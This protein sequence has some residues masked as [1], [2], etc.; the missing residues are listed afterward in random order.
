ML[1]KVIFSVSLS[2]YFCIH[3]AHAFELAPTNPVFDAFMLQGPA[4]TAGETDMAPAAQF[5]PGVIP[6]P[7]KPEVHVYEPIQDELSLSGGILEISHY[8]LRDPN[9]DGNFEDSLLTAVK[10]QGY[11]GS[12]WSFATFGAL[13]GA[14]QFNQG[15]VIDGNNYSENHLINAHLFDYGPCEGGNLYMSASYLARYSGPVQDTDDPY[16]PSAQGVWCDTCQPSFYVDAVHFLPGRSGPEDV[17]YIKQAILEYGP[18]ATEMFWDSNYYTPLDAGYSYPAENPEGM[19]HAVVIVGWDD[20]LTISE[21]DQPGA[22]IVRNS[23]GDGWGHDGYFYVSYADRMFAKNSLA[24]YADQDDQLLPFDQLYQHDPLGM[25]S[26]LFYGNPDTVYGANVFNITTSGWLKAIGIY[27]YNSDTQC[28]INIY[29][30]A[31]V[32]GNTATF[33]ALATTQATEPL[34][35]GYHT[36]TLDSPVHISEG[37][38]MAIVVTYTHLTQTVRCPIEHRFMGYSS[39]AAASPGESYVSNNGLTF[40]DITTL[41]PSLENDNVCIKALVKVD[42]DIDVDPSI[43]LFSTTKS[44]QQVAGMVHM[45]KGLAG[46]TWTNTSTSESG[47]FSF[48]VYEPQPLTDTIVPFSSSIPLGHYQNYIDIVAYDNT[49]LAIG[50]THITITRLPSGYET[51]EIP[52]ITTIEIP[53]YIDIPVYKTVTQYCYIWNGL[54]LVK[55]PC[56]VKTVID[57][58]ETVLSHY[59][60]T[61]IIDGYETISVEIWDD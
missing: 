1:K 58:Y 21:S 34:T 32:S 57:H 11:C 50:R 59:E 51:I 10:D 16:D 18:V 27:V 31:T 55:K 46:L 12:C 4:Y 14:L 22:F 54:Y 38:H 29:K 40:Q 36:I 47:S 3:C 48:G 53:V 30:S 60:T 25:T 44:Q 43:T 23:W 37:D 28:E 49:N 20:T 6:S 52:I 26:G 56:G 33:D 61:E 45:A 7:L 15:A 17:D 39:T 41:D 8:D 35:R 13:E 19:N 2:F 9:N 24:Y 42:C 5:L